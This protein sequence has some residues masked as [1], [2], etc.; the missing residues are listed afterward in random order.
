VSKYG[1]PTL[2]NVS[3]ADTEP[4]QNRIKVLFTWH[5]AVT[6]GN[7][8]YVRHLAAYPDL[9]VYLL[10]PPRWDESVSMVETSIAGDEG[11]K[12]IIGEVENPFKGLSFTY[13]NARTYLQEIQPD[14]IFMYEE[15]YSSV[16]Y[17][18]VREKMR[19]CPQARFIF[20]TWQN[21][22][23]K[24][25]LRRRLTERYVFKHTDTAVAG[26]TDVQEVLLHRKYKGRIST[27]PLALEPSDFPQADRGIIRRELG[28][29]DFTLGFVGRP[30]EEKGITDL[31]DAV[32]SMKERRIQI[33]FVG[34]GKN[35][36][37]IREHAESVGIA[38]RLIWVKGVK[39]SEIYK[40]YRAMDVLVLPSRT[41]EYWKEQF[42]R[43]IIEAMICRT[44]VIGSSSGEIPRV[45]GDA[46]L[47]FTERNVSELKAAI[48]KMMDNGALRE[49]LAGRGCERVMQ[50][51]TWEKVAELTHAAILDACGRT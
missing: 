5:A 49:E 1:I 2:S 19:Y 24:Y 23:C 29:T 28:I 46:G 18:F 30:E 13:K 27:I 40:Y 21:M 44:A 33:L 38:D 4:Q 43:V 48:I 6:S 42:G 41:T 25:S 17:Q 36:D 14:V 34:G 3:M 7:Q 31:F 51:Y 32:A 16:A 8:Y 47:I 11:F 20:C 26:S 35:E 22:R 12:T 9:E 45:V 50:N 37:K 15:P 39:N 10:V